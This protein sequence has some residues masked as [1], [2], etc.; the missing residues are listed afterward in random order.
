VRIEYSTA[1]LSGSYAFAVTGEGGQAPFAALGLLRFDGRGRVSGLFTENRRADGSGARVLVPVSYEGSYSLTA[2]GLGSISRSDSPQPDLR[3]VVQRGESR[4]GRSTVEELTCVFR[5]ED[6][7]TGCLRSGYAVRR[8]DGL[9]FDGRSLRGR[10]GG[11]AVS[12]GS[13]VPL[14]GVGVNAYDGESTFA[15]ANVASVPG[16]QGRIF[17]EGSDRGAFTMGPDGIGTVA[18]GAVLNI[19]MRASVSDGLPLAEEYWFMMK[20]VAPTGAHFTGFMRRLSD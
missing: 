19:I 5:Q 8:P 13:A 10:Y 20:S 7:S 6:E 3:F 18:N 2:Q 9:V 1:S 4:E 11:L 15:E 14:A 12:R 17:V 16:P